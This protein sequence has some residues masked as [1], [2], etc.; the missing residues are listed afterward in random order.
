MK[1]WQWIVFSLLSYIIFLVMYI[2][3]SY[4][5]QLVNQQSN[6]QV[7]M[8]QVSGTLFDGK[9][10]VVEAKGFRVNNIEW[11]LKPLS[12]LLLKANLQVKGGAIRDSEQIYI[13][14]TASVKLLSANQLFLQDSQIFVPAK[15][16]LSQFRLPVA[17]TA[18][19]RFR[20]DIEKLEMTPTCTLLS[21]KG[22]WINAEVDTPQQA[23]KLGN[24]DAD[25]SCSEGDLSVDIKPGNNLQL[26][27]R[28][29]V[30]QAGNYSI[31][32]QFM[33]NEDLPN[34]IKQ[35]A[36]SFFQRDSQ[37]FYQIRL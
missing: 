22:A 11:S 9:A 32:G 28:I 26:S 4:L 1:T 23:V 29:I 20:V 5:A 12:L 8:M 34:A 37:G 16:A 36:D 35:A 14:T 18:S 17:V 2:P 24:F 25:L 27:G 10:G 21:G 13:D 15:A 7:K 33:P 3:A 31:N 6:Q 19:G 30:D